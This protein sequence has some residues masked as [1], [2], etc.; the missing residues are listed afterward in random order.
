[1]KSIGDGLH[2][3]IRNTYIALLKSLLLIESDR[4]PI[5]AKVNSFQILV[6]GAK[7]LDKVHA[8]I[9]GGDEMR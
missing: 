1:M 4:G 2:S 3:F 6:K 5:Q 9:P 8:D 7:S